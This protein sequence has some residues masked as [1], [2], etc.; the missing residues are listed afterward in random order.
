MTFLLGSTLKVSIVLLAGLA[1]ATLLRRRSAAARHW[2]IAVSLVCAMVLPALEL[3]VPAWAVPSAW[4]A[5]TATATP[6]AERERGND[7]G[8]AA[9]ALEFSET[10]TVPPPS[11]GR[12]GVLRFLTP[13]WIAGAC[14]SLFVLSVGLARLTWLASRARPVEAGSWTR[15]ADEIGRDLALGRPVRLLESDHPSLLVTWGLFVPKVI[16]PRAAQSWTDERAAIVLRHELAHIR[17]GDWVI[18]IAGEL[19]RTVYWFNPLVWM[20]CARLRQES[21]QACDDEVLTSGVDGPDY[22]THLVDL[23][24]L[25]KAEG[26]PRLPAPAIARSSSLERRIRA[27]LDARLTRTPATRVARFMTAGALV[28]FTVALAAAQTG[29]V[30]LSGVV[31]DQSGAPVPGATVVLTNTQRQAKFEVKSDDSGRFEFV[32]LPADTYALATTLP[33][34]KKAEDTVTLTGKTVK[35]DVTLSLGELQETI[36]VRASQ[37]IRLENG[38]LVTPDGKTVEFRSIEMDVPPAGKGVAV[39]GSFKG[40]PTGSGFQQALENCQPSTSGGRVRP[41]RKLKDVKPIY[42]T[43]LRESQTSGKVGLKATIAV[44]GTVR[45]VQVVNSAHPD[46]DAAAMEAVRQWLF[47]G[48]LLN[49]TPVE[50]TMN[51]SVDFGIQ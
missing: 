47:D 33:G 8:T 10:V 32:P 39:R 40:S 16:L 45:D 35:R 37:V 12:I 38:T 14:L 27:M 50:V 17:R 3:A 46:L 15:L 1:A 20:A 19:L 7:G 44:D 2:V 22:A 30:T 9:P 24:R 41:P 43:N 48:T 51:V 6:P 26:A 28:A 49:C 5:A 29:P 21:E 11:P 36:S 31:I 42:P 18:Q 13:A 23:A 25:L 4:S 34:F